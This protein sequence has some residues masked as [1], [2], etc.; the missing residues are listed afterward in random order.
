M[1]NTATNAV[2]GMAVR[3]TTSADWQPISVS[4]KKDGAVMTREDFAAYDHF[5]L[6]VYAEEAGARLY[7]YNHEVV[8]LQQG[9]NIVTITAEAFLAQYDAGGTAAYSETG[10]ATWQIANGAAEYTLYFDNLIGVYP[11]Q[12]PAA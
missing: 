5:E 12:T 1:T 3:F 8:T 10:F 4:M 6:Y 11:E 9:V 2:D 7:F